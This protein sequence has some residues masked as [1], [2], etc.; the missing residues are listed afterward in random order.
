[1][2]T[3]LQEMRKRAGFQSAVAFAEHYGISAGTYTNY[4]QG[5]RS[6]TLEKAWEFADLLGCSLDELAG[7][8]WPPEG[9]T[10]PA[11]PMREELVR[12]YDA[13]TAENRHS[14]VV[15]ARNAA[16]ASGEAAERGADTEGVSA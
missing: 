15:A 10:A 3:R 7:R 4:E 14:L 11:D 16:L 9:A 13:S 12:C 2:K 6:L 5:K 1:M 8:Q